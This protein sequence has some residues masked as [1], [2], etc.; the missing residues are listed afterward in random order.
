[1][2]QAVTKG[3]LDRSDILRQMRDLSS[4]NVSD[5]VFAKYFE[6]DLEAA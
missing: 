5:K 2:D 6:H 4:R 1:M 3:T